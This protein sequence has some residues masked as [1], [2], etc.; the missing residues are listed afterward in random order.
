MGRICVISSAG[1]AAFLIVGCTS[2]GTGTSG[3]GVEAQKALTSKFV[4]VSP[5]AGSR[6]V[7]GANQ[8][9]VTY[10]HPLPAGAELPTLTP[11]IPGTWQRRGDEAIFTPRTGFTQ[12]T[13]VTVSIP[14]IGAAGS[15][16]RTTSTTAK[17][18]TFTTGSYSTLRL[19]ELLAQL[20]YLPIA[21]T[22]SAKSR[23]VNVTSP[24]QQLSA[25]YD[26]PAGSFSWDSN[27]YPSSLYSFWSQGTPNTLTKGALTGF[28]G[29]HGMTTDGNASPAVWSALLK[30]AAADQVNTYGY[31]YALVS[32][33][34]D[35]ETITI[36]HDG[37]QAF[38]SVTN[39]GISVAPTPVGTFPVYERLPFQ[40]MSGTN[41]DGSSYADPVQWVSYFSGGAAVHYFVRGTYGWPQSL[42]CVELPLDAAKQAYP[43]LPYGT[44][45]TVLPE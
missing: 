3:T 34:A 20:G 17:I 13:R 12:R 29:D 43:L 39:T 22:A 26:P 42:G 2:G 31:S 30:A 10:S 40:I 9:T 19:Q 23:P 27:G 38:R 14:V 15:R 8:V 5:A 11:A 32:Q 45:V 25:A 33:S 21:W 35:P 4:S 7:N 6:N 24:R 28:E 44:L 41:P 36:W 37:K 1:L 16:V 18:V